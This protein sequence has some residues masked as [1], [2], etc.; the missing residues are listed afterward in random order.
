MGALVA[1]D[2]FGDNYEDKLGIRPLAYERGSLARRNKHGRGAIARAGI[3]VQ[4]GG[5]MWCSFA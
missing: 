4:R 1:G 5:S 2:N 3:P